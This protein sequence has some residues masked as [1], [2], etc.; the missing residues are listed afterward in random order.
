LQMGIVA[1]LSIV[2]LYLAF[3][4]GQSYLPGTIILGVAFWFA[5]RR[6]RSSALFVLA[7]V[8]TLLL[9][10]FYFYDLSRPAHY[11]LAFSLSQLVLT[12]ALLGAL[13][14]VSGLVAHYAAPES[15]W[16]GYAHALGIATNVVGVAALLGLSS[17][18]GW[19]RLAAAFDGATIGFIVGGA[20]LLAVA[21]Q[22]VTAPISAGARAAFLS[23]A[24]GWLVL[25]GGLVDRPAGLRAILPLIAALFALGI[26]GSL[27][28][29]GVR[30]LSLARLV[31][32]VA[33][34]V[35]ESLALAL[36]WSTQY[37]SSALIAFGAAVVVFVVAYRYRHSAEPTRIT[38][39]VEVLG[40]KPGEPSQ[41]V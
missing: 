22:I 36:E 37:L 40:L 1:A 38:Q 8:G 26:A 29:A 19:E 21:S 28:I 16:K 6:R 18:G 14:G 24:G 20:L 12:L 41:G 3:L 23:W 5:L 30:R 10:N 11:P 35:L 31:A 7:V 27:L 15:R 34:L 33:V 9:A 39:P 32:G 25:A 13:S 17:R 2:W 4:Y